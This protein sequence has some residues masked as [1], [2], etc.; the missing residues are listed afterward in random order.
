[1]FSSSS[2]S[3][4]ST[5]SPNTVLPPLYDESGASA[6]P[7]WEAAK[8][9]VLVPD[10]VLKEYEPCSFEAWMASRKKENDFA[11]PTDLKWSTS[12]KAKA[13][14]D[15]AYLLSEAVRHSYNPSY[16]NMPWAFHDLDDLPGFA[17]GRTL[18]ALFPQGYDELDQRYVRWDEPAKCWRPR[19]RK[20]TGITG[21]KGG[22]EGNGMTVL[23]TKPREPLATADAA[24]G[25]TWKPVVV[26]FKTG[27][28]CWGGPTV[29]EEMSRRK[30]SRRNAD[31]GSFIGERSDIG[32]IDLRG[33]VAVV[34]PQAQSVRFETCLPPRFRLIF[35]VDPEKVPTV[36]LHG[37]TNEVVTLEGADLVDALAMTK[38]LK[39]T[40]EMQKPFGVPNRHVLLVVPKNLKDLRKVVD[41]VD[42]CVN[43]LLVDS[44]IPV[45]KID[46]G[47]VGEAMDVV[48]KYKAA[49]V[50]LLGVCRMMGDSVD[51]ACIDTIYEKRKTLPD[52]TSA[53]Q[54]YGRAS[55][56]HGTMEY[57]E[58]V[59][60]ARLSKSLRADTLQD[61]L[62]GLDDSD[63]KHLVATVAMH[64]K[65]FGTGEVFVELCDG[66]SLQEVADGLREGPGGGKRRK[67]GKKEGSGGS[68]GTMQVTETTLEDLQELL[69]RVR[70][71]RAPPT[72]LEQVQ[73]LS[74]YAA[75]NGGGSF[76]A[77]R[78][79]H[80]ERPEW[81]WG[82]W[83]TNLSQDYLNGKL[84]DSDVREAMEKCPHWCAK[85]DT[86]REKREAKA[87]R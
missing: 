3:P 36:R 12:K 46:S 77:R 16:M 60:C 30:L 74:A 69:A 34:F 27:G 85:L 45:L 65:Y 82:R 49:P 55:R 84:K 28:G 58:V 35:F 4:S 33:R 7:A 68:T 67:R 17:D 47:D 52:W 50:S 63:L 41:G 56:R 40:D 2:S 1:M 78:A 73:M 54:R 44:D 13:L 32:P 39:E 51:I 6:S 23:W 80:P 87:A 15:D 20:E 48:E 31:T 57:F 71:D 79:P 64:R 29:A 81:K 18:D 37:A 83:A 19:L 62:E 26:R 86:L 24:N 42:A 61:F 11:I 72:R 5:R 66:D 10:D 70:M 38:L 21:Q 75:E 14:E 25:S 22:I 8:K 43:K 76:P 53:V 59:M 9:A